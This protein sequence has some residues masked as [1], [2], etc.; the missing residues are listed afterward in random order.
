[1]A[2]SQELDETKGRRFTQKAVDDLGA[3]MTIIMCTLGDRLGLFKDLAAGGPTT[4][5]GLAKRTGINERY[6][7]EWL[8]GLACAGYLEYDPA[9][10]LFTLPAEYAPVLAHEGGRVFLGGVYQYVPAMLST[11]DLLT[12]AFKQG[13]G[14]AQAD[15]DLRM[16][17][18][19]ARHTGARFDNLLV[20]RWIPDMP[21]VQAKLENG[22]LVADVGSGAGI[23]LIRM[24][25]AFP[26]SRFVGFDVY[27]PNVETATANAREAGVEDR[28]RFEQQNVAEGLPGSYDVI[29]TFDVVHDAVDPGGLIASIRRGL[30][31]DGLYVVLEITCS[32]KLEENIGSAGAV[33][34]GISMMYCMTTSLAGGGEGLGTMG[35]PEP[36][37]LEL[38]TGA[39][40]S[41][42][43][44]VWEDAFATLY[45]VRP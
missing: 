8:S 44:R 9:S 5:E 7:R 23:A 3:A 39:G 38:A 19:M 26:K 12:E 21:E 2:S 29:T 6:A 16:W 14:V 28:V 13:G 40:F 31:D 27:R 1:M 4:C 11:L 33:K 45:E 25:Q 43:R 32:D 34:F 24:A 37:L 41:S 42:V 17:D 10:G 15:F 22:A 18:G 20:R 35:L 30:K 36:K